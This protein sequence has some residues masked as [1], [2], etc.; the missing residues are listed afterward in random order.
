MLPDTMTHLTHTTHIHVPKEEST[1]Q[2]TDR[3][4]F[5][6]E[7]QSS[8]PLM[9]NTL[10]HTILRLNCVSQTLWS[11]L[12]LCKRAVPRTGERRVLHHSH[13]CLAQLE[14][15][16][17]CH[18]AHARL[19]MMLC[20]VAVARCLHSSPAASESLVVRSISSEAL[21]A[22]SSTSAGVYILMDHARWSITAAFLQDA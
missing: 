21:V 12:A 5:K 10:Y 15:E 20:L 8:Q 19:K 18:A 17:L 6:K 7:Q 22:R 1:L 3:K 11:K 4:C 14:R 2:H 13:S 16:Q 9:C